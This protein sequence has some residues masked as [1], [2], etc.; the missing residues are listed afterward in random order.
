M[1]SVFNPGEFE[2]YQINFNTNADS[3]KLLLPALA[4]PVR[5]Q[6]PLSEALVC[7]TVIRHLRTAR[8][9]QEGRDTSRRS[10]HIISFCT[11]SNVFFSIIKVAV[12]LM[13]TS[14]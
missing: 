13:T 7:F 14:T 12:F 4:D 10:S 9:H 11:T 3:E 1:L 6:V 5:P 2:I 8:I